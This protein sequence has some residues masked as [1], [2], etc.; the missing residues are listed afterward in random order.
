MIVQSSV[1]AVKVLNHDRNKKIAPRVRAMPV[2]GTQGGH[3]MA[4]MTYGA[5][6][7]MLR[8]RV[9]LTQEQLS[10]A[11]GVTRGMI[12]NVECGNRRFG[13]EAEKV[14]VDLGGCNREFIADA[15]LKAAP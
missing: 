3:G 2:C 8:E 10:E 11:L 12:A 5:R 6:V 14:L 4:V 9:G 15:P 7:R 13:R 1:A